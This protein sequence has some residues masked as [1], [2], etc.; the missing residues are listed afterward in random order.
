MLVET[1]DFLVAIH[2]TARYGVSLVELSKFQNDLATIATSE[3]LPDKEWFHKIK[4]VAQ[5]KD[6]KGLQTLLKE[7]RNCFPHLSNYPI[8]AMA[9]IRGESEEQISRLQKEAL[10][11]YYMSRFPCLVVGVYK[12]LRRHPRLA[13]CMMPWWRFKVDLGQRISATDL[14][15]SDISGSIA[16]NLRE[17]HLLEIPSSIKKGITSY[18]PV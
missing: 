7:Y 4:E 6:G 15:N 3:V 14:R 9:I 17:L 2:N 8:K 13:T 11:K 16:S 10:Y 1:S 18:S 5:I 12:L